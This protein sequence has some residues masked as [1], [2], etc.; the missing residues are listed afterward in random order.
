MGKI[1]WNQSVIYNDF[2]QSAQRI[3]SASITSCTGDSD[4]SDLSPA[5]VGF[6]LFSV[7]ITPQK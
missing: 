3:Y 1:L 5:K 2:R 7:F 6:S 4:V